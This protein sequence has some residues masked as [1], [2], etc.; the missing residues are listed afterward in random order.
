M[1][2]LALIGIITHVLSNVPKS[3]IQQGAL[4]NVRYAFNSTLKVTWIFP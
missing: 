4:L 1:Y 2:D 3:A